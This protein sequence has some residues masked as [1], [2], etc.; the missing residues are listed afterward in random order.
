[1]LQYFQG[2]SH[3][4]KDLRQ[5]EGNLLGIKFTDWDKTTLAKWLLSDRI[6]D[7]MLIGR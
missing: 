2:R 6:P 1:M 5:D 3:L 4:D 7:K